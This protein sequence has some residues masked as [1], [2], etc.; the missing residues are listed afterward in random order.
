LASN[1]DI[2]TYDVGNLYVCTEGQASTATVGYLYIDYEVVL[3]T[4]QLNFDDVLLGGAIA[5]GGSLT[6]G[7]PL[8]ATASVDPQALGISVGATSVVTL[9]YPGTYIVSALYAGTVFSDSACAG[10]A[11][12]AVVELA[13]VSPTAATS[14]LAQYYVLSTVASGTLSFTVT[15]TTVTSGTVIVASVPANSI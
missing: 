15:A 7:N 12:V 1:L 11:G 14:R 8:G 3:K 2:K 9:A 5:S 10:S 13:D 4:P 6:A